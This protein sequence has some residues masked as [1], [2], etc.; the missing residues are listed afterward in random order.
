MACTAQDLSTQG[1]CL[2]TL[3]ERQLLASIAYQLAVAA[4]VEPTPAVLVGQAK[5]LSQ[6]MGERQL[7]ASIA[8]LQCQINSGGGGSGDVLG[9]DPSGNILGLDT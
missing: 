1:E 6:A 7:L 8:Y 2:L 5:C 9:T 4:G 3:S